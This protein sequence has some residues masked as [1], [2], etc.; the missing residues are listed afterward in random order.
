MRGASTAGTQFGLDAF[1]NRFRDG[2]RGYLFYVTPMFPSVKG[3]NSDNEDMAY[4]VRSTSMPSISI[5]ELQAQWQGSTYKVGGPQQFSNWTL[6]FHV[7][8]N[9]TIYDKYNKWVSYIHDPGTGTH[10]DP[11]LY[12]VDQPIQLLDGVSSG[13]IFISAVE[14]YGAFPTQI[15]D[16]RLDHG[17]KD[18]ATFSV[19]YSYQYHKIISSLTNK[20][21]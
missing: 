6:D 13:E 19:T 15:S 12:M 20:S 11:S 21:S 3:I 16:I 5:A 8:I 17:S 10:G 9:A 7:D 18:F 2:A 14:L 4:L 1:R